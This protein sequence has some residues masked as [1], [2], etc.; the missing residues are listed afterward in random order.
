MKLFRRGLRYIETKRVPEEPL[1]IMGVRIRV[2][3]K[4]GVLLDSTSEYLALIA[5]LNGGQLV[6][7]V[8]AVLEAPRDGCPAKPALVIV[9][10]RNTQVPEADLWVR[11]TPITVSGS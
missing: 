6:H 3:C 10:G 9:D 1:P 4:A 8:T 7:S 2:E 11:L 5:Q